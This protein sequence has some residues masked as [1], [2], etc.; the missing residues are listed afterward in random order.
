ME[1]PQKNVAVFFGGRSNEAEISVITGMYAVNLLRGTRYRVLPVWLPPEGGMLLGTWNKVSEFAGAVRG[2]PVALMRGALA[3]AGRKKPFVRVDVALNCC[4]GGM[5]EDGTLAALL[6][7]AHIP[8]ASPGVPESALF[9]D[10]AF[11]KIA[12]RGLDI[13]AAPFFT[14]GERE[15]AA[16][17]DNVF[18]CAAAFGYP[19]VVKPARLGSSIGL[20]VA[21]GQKELEEALSL[22]FTLDDK[23]LVERY[24]EGKR[25]INCAACR[26]D[27]EVRVS[28]C[29]E[30]F[31]AGELLTYAEKYEAGKGAQF[32]ARLPAPLAAQIAGYTRRLYEAFGMRGV[33]RA[34]FLVVGQEA[35]FNELNIVPGS[36]AGYLFGETLAKIRAFFAA[37]LDEALREAPARKQ[38]LKT[39]I[40]SEG[41]FSGAKGCK[42]RGNFV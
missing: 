28:A 26:L 30:V 25:D 38:V 42:R 3:R 11:T 10:K 1:K 18:G 12:A 39:G 19:V 8:S 29:E 15:F 36:L 23:A 41:I 14:V 9:M 40:L 4:H 37:L 27:G 35:Y 32:P 7:W 33:V 22:A 6:A 31:S 24:F 20:T 5:G 2:T 21:H 34:D 17:P 13:P 16:S